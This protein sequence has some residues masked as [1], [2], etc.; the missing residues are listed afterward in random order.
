M[1]IVVPSF[2]ITTRWGGRKMRRKPRVTRIV[3]IVGAK[4]I[5][6]AQLSLIQREGELLAEFDFEGR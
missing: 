3:R 1:R 5:A 2:W 4:A 6:R